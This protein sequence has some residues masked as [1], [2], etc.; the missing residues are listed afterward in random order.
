V[1]T[2]KGPQGYILGTGFPDGADDKPTFP[3]DGCC[4]R[5]FSHVNKGII[6]IGIIVIV[7]VRIM[8]MI[9]IMITKMMM[10]IA[11]AIAII[12]INKKGGDVGH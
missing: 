11:I 3:I 9:M 12:I 7:I 6:V 2:S 1:E 5:K 8:I 10:I 4:S